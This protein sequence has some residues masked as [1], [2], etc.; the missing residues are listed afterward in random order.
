V[1]AGVPTSFGSFTASVKAADSWDPSRAVVLSTTITVAPLP[2]A[3]STT[4]LASGTVRQAYTATLAATGGTGSTTW[5]LAGGTLPSG[6]A[7][8]ANGVVSGTPTTAGTFA[9]TVQASDAG[10]PGNIAT[11]ALKISVGAREAVLYASDATVVAG[12]WSLVADTTAAGG[13]R[14]W[15]PDKGAAKLTAPLASPANYFEM[16]FQAEAGVAYHVWLRG[17][18]DNNYWGNDS[19]M[20]QFSNSTDATG[21]AKSRIG[22]TSALDVNLEDCSGCGESGW[23]WQDN[24]YGVNVLGSDVYFAQS[25]AQTI[26]VQVKEDGFSIDQIVLSADKY[27]T[28]SPGALKND[29]TILPRQ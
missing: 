17:K 23:G 8:G 10:W 5:S 20:V 13:K 12:T 28:V 11:Q 14:I 15:N 3:I 19:V 9:F 18:A 24:G 1:V 4:T 21:A 26:R 6:L 16:T 29:T 22:T 7:L 27:H 25:G 2:L